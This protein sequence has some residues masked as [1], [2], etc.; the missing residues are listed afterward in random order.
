MSKANFWGFTM[1][2]VLYRRIDFGFQQI[3]AS[4][5]APR[6]PFSDREGKRTA[7]LR[8]EGGYQRYPEGIRATSGLPIIQSLRTLPQS[9]YGIQLLAAVRS[10]RGS[11]SPP[12]CNSLSRRRFA[13]SHRESFFISRKRYIEPLRRYIDFNRYVF[14]RRLDIFRRAKF[15]ICGF[16][17][18]DMFADV[19]PR[20]NK[21]HR[22]TP[23]ANVK[24]PGGS[25]R[26]PEGAGVQ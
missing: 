4:S 19:N 23:A 2:T 20:S 10:R 25:Q 16:A 12:D 14:L 21:L 15:D 3:R 26:K 1:M 5:T 17:A 8:E 22:G 9:A 24:A 18:F 6:F 7:F 13:P 11:Y